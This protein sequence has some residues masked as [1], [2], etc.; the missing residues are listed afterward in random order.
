[1]VGG[2]TAGETPG[3]IP[4]PEVKT[5][6]GVDCAVLLHGASCKLPTILSLKGFVMKRPARVAK[7]LKKISSAASKIARVPSKVR[8]NYASKRARKTPFSFLGWESKPLANIPRK[9]L[10][11]EPKLG[12][13]PVHLLRKTI[14]LKTGNI[15]DQHVPLTVGI[16]FHKADRKTVAV[17]FPTQV[18]D[19]LKEGFV[20]ISNKTTSWQ[21]SAFELEEAN[22]REV[23]LKIGSAM[24]IKPEEIKVIFTRR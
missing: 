18:E 23:A 3:L 22:L 1:M 10:R 2:H 15:V 6:V 19:I 13:E 21:R 24:G 9:F 7:P 8:L 11:T 16:S 5:R 20:R 4:N 17:V 12:A 14:E